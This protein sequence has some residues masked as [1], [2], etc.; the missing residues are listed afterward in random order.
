MS[1][2]LPFALIYLVCQQVLKTRVWLQDYLDSHRVLL[3]E[4]RDR[5]AELEQSRSDWIHVSRQLALA[6]ER[7]ASLRLTAEKAHA[8]KASFVARVSHEFRTPLNIIIGM[9]ALMVESPE[10]YAEK[11]PKKAMEQLRIVYSNCQHLA[12][13][14][15]DVLDLS[16]AEAGKMVLRRANVDIQ[17]TIQTALSVVRPLAQEKGLILTF[18][19]PSEVPTVY[20]DSV[21][22]RQV[23][24]NL[25]SNALRYT[26]SGYVSVSL[27]VK[28]QALQIGVS[29][30]GPGIP[31]E[32]TVRIF[33]PFACA[34]QRLLRERAGSGLGL[35]ISQELV[36]QHGG[37]MWLE[38][39]LGAGS[40][41][42]FEL[43]ISAPLPPVEL[44]SSHIREDWIWR[45]RASRAD[46]AEVV[47][48][49]RFIV[50]ETGGALR[51]ALQH[52]EERAELLYVDDPRE[53]AQE[54][55]T[56][57]AH[58]LL[59]GSDSPD[60]LWPKLV[61]AREHAPITPIIG[62]CTSTPQQ[63]NLS[64]A[65]VRYLEKPILKENLIAAIKSISGRVGRVL[66]ADDDA[67]TREWLETVLR[68]YDATIEVVAVDC[69]TK[70]LEVMEREHPDLLLL[71]VVMTGMTGWEVLAH[72][73]TNVSLKE[74]PVIM[75]SARDLLEKP[76]RGEILM[77]TIEH[78]LSMGKVLSLSAALSSI[79][80]GP[81]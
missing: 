11:F 57:P 54:L 2:T 52:Y 30:T 19:A 28:G 17:E 50:C 65:V 78:G 44:P 16:Q 60:T 69:G 81:D 62:C 47:S 63:P 37:R 53:A 36:K 8:D 39:E 6:N 7:L 42:Y 26:D 22:V 61:D 13:M 38:T 31:P 68:A 9:V 29:D 24:L 73:E 20:C 66:V 58:A 12:S 10:I 18:A 23:I 34:N 76:P 41:F 51:N 72:L 48:R 80:L 40:S 27:Q 74:T 56:S 14:I 15:D 45:Q 59:I 77:A 64:P 21:R 4:A 32:E 3:D 25:L 79:M 5:K 46:L 71:D 35:S 1:I 49:Q 75:I 43:P 55:Q 67:D 33:E 70:A